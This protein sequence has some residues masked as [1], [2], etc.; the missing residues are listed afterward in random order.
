MLIGLVGEAP[1]D[2]G[3]LQNLLSKRYS[4]SGIVFKTLLHDM[5]GD[6]LQ[7]KEGYKFLRLENQL[8]KPDFII[9]IRDLDALW[10]D[11]KKRAERVAYFR[12]SI[13]IVHRKGIYLLHVFEIEALIF[14]DIAS[15]NKEYKTTIPELKN[16]ADVTLIENPKEVLRN[17]SKGAYKESHNEKHFAKVDFDKLLEVD[18][19]K[20]FIAEFEAKLA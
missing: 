6:M 11:R 3:A 19:F 20:E 18:Y 13:N 15:F 12:K 17:L 4:G 14:A 8:E 5:T 9:F 7:S 2:T 1:N 10:T 16:I